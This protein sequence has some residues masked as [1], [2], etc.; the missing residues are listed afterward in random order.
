MGKL[1]Q[2]KLKEA[3]TADIGT[4][5]K[6]WSNIFLKLKVKTWLIITSAILSCIF[7][8]L[9]HYVVPNVANRI[10][11]SWSESIG[12]KTESDG[13]FVDLSDAKIYSPQVRVFDDFST[14][15]IVETGKVALNFSGWKLFLSLFGFGDW[16]LSITELTIEQPRVLI[17][18]NELGKW[19]LQ[20]LSDSDYWNQ[21][22]VD[23]LSGKKITTGYSN[24]VV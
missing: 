8:T 16:R 10:Q 5:K 23:Q 3:K 13:W 21:L 7:F 22:T 17:Q 18:K 6:T 24:G 9:F 15:P 14:E 4:I 11:I 2:P 19:N 1:E 20:T 12:V